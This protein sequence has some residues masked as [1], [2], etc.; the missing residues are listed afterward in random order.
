MLWFIFYFLLPPPAFFCKLILFFLALSL[1]DIPR[2]KFYML[3][4]KNIQTLPENY[5]F[6]L[7]M[8]DEFH[9]KWGELCCMRVTSFVTGY[10]MYSSSTILVFTMGNG[11]NGFTL[12]PTIGE[13]V[14]THPDIQVPKRGKVK[15]RSQ[16]NPNICFWC[17]RKKNKTKYFLKEFYFFWRNDFLQEI[18][19]VH[20]IFLK[21]VW[22]F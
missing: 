4:Y 16:K 6:I 22:M 13:F 9:G 7:S 8:Y 19:F 20:I 12:D 18:L 15:Q 1:K 5:V 11:V 14:L 17:Y 3:Q 21:L 10:C 2:T